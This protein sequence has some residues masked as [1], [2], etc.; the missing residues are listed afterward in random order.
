M[1]G[2]RGGEFIADP[3]TAGSITLLLQASLPCCLLGQR[4]DAVLLK[5][6]GGTNT[7][8]APSTDFMKLCL[9]P[10]LTTFFGV[11]EENLQVTIK[12]RGYY[13]LGGGEVDF[14]II[15]VR[16][17]TPITLLE[18][19]LPK[20]ITISAFGGGTG[21]KLSKDVARLVKQKVSE[22]FPAVD[23]VM[24]V[25]EEPDGG[26]EKK[27]ETRLAIS[28]TTTTS[29]GKGQYGGKPNNKN[30]GR[31]DDNATMTFKERRAA[32]EEKRRKNAGVS[33][34]Q[35]VLQ[36]T[37][38]AFITGDSLVLEAGK[39]GAVQISATE[40]SDKAVERLK[41]AWEKGRGCVD[42]YLMD[43]LIIFMALAKGTSKVLCPAPTS[44]SSLHIET[45]IHFSELLCGVKFR[46][47]DQGDGTK[48]IECE[49]MG[50]GLQPKY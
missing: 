9:F 31:S 27:L 12:K 37:T 23:I 41:E 13:P 4:T 35:V 18:R 38:G 21:K 19:G 26:E 3:H 49:G 43:Q 36:T 22:I 6:R 15:P 32:A 11:P 50:F 42:E 1:P 47:E 17:L 33:G 29:S 20:K 44:I 40:V 25:S 46:V 24:M 16:S 7:K 2:L 34:C 28:T 30:A 39:T 10:V 5:L 45:A 14:K 48:I 8:G